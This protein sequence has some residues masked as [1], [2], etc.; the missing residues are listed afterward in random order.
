[1][2]QGTREVKIGLFVFIAFILLAVMVFSISDFYTTQA[3]YTYPLRIRFSYVSGIE[4]GAPVRLAGVKVGEV[5]VVRTYRDEANQRTLAEVK[6]RVSKDAILETDSVAYINTLGFIGEKYLEIIPG[7]PG[8]ETLG[9]NDILIGKDSVPA[10]KLVEAGYD[11]VKQME[12]TVA[13]VHEVIGDEATQESLKS[14]FA[15]SSDA[16]DELKRLL[17]QSNEIM[18]RVRKGEGTIGKLLMEEE[19]YKDVK[20]TV[21]DV[22]AHP[23]KLFFRTKDKKKKR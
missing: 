1:M 20:E 17:A 13:A 14:T 11:A 18:E 23:W 8:A 2:A 15:S 5:R 3:Q 21:A 7:T 10:E 9:A 19:I 12:K 22:K 16:M 4:V 6:V